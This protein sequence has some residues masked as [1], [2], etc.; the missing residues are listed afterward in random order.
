MTNTLNDIKRIRSFDAPNHT[1]IF[2]ISK[3][4]TIDNSSFS[5]NRVDDL[6]LI[7]AIKLTEASKQVVRKLLPIRGIE[8]LCFK[9]YQVEI[10]LARVFDW[11]EVNNQILTIL[12]EAY[13]PGTWHNDEYYAADEVT[14]EHITSPLDEVASALLS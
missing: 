4:L 10:Q 12:Q 6:D 5:V 7:L 3:E 2:G 1:R 8:Q 11:S 9:P 13:F 14:I